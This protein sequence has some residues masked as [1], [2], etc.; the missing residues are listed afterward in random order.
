M[1]ND[2]ITVAGDYQQFEGAAGS[3]G[4]SPGELLEVDGS[5]NF[6]SHSSAPDLNG[7]GSAAGWVAVEFPEVGL[8]IDDDYSSG[9]G[10]KA[11]RYTPGSKVRMFIP[12]GVDLGGHVPL[13]SAGNGNLQ[14][15]TGLDPAGDGTDTIAGDLVVAYTPPG[16]IDTT[17]ESS[18]TLQEVIIA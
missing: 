3:D 12:S 5:G 9:D 18:A 15:H 8:G 2:S 4:L 7:N 17:G 14:Q 16:G 6:D 10:M 13:E 11:R 1:S